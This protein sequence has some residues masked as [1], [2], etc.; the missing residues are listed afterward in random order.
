MQP[1]QVNTNLQPQSKGKSI[2]STITAGLN[3]LVNEVEKGITKASEEVTK[4]WSEATDQRFRNNFKELPADERLL[5]EYWAQCVTGGKT[6]SC[7]C[8]VSTNFFSFIVDLPTGKA[9]VMVLLRE[10]V[11]IQPAVALRSTGLAPVIQPATDAHTK[12][13]ALQVFTRDMKLHQFFN[14]LHFDKAYHALLH[15]WQVL[16][17]PQTYTTQGYIPSPYSGQSSQS[18]MQ[19]GTTQLDKSYLTSPVTTTAQ[20]IAS[21]FPQQFTNGAAYPTSQSIY[22]AQVQAVPRSD[23]FT[24]SAVQQEEP[25]NL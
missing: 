23:P 14:F 7:V 11:N 6:S 25:S 15:A 8:Y 5:G 22:S 10:V 4:A 2:L 3:T 24:S 16:Q 20:P 18:T 12:A 9:H 1:Q 19:A 13:D 17:T 21:S